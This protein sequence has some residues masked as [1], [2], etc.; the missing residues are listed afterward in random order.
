M[1]DLQNIKAIT[2]LDD[3]ILIIDD[4][5]K[6]DVLKTVMLFNKL[7]LVNK[8]LSFEDNIRWLDSILPKQGGCVDLV[9]MS[10]IL[11]LTESPW[12]CNS[13]FLVLERGNKEKRTVSTAD[14]NHVVFL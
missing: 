4:F 12:F 6:L 9:F 3:T 10:E 11:H 14:F 8:I 7:I 13:T 2:D 1:L 5:I